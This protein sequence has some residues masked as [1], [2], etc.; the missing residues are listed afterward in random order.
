MNRPARMERHASPQIF[1][2]E[3]KLKKE[4]NKILK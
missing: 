1:A 3:S 2:K 4:E